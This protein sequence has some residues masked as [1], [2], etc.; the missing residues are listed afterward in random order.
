[1]FDG[2]LVQINKLKNIITTE[3]EKDVFIAV[4]DDKIKEDESD[5]NSTEKTAHVKE[6]VEKLDFEL[7]PTEQGELRN[8]AENLT[9]TKHFKLFKKRLVFI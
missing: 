5:N 2:N 8:N 9:K 4:C 3:E 7:L 1:M 6:F